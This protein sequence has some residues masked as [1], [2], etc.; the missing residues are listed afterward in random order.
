MRT[1]KVLCMRSFRFCLMSWC[2]KLSAKNC[3]SITRLTYF[4]QARSNILPPSIYLL[5]LSKNLFSKNL[6]RIS[7]G[8]RVWLLVQAAHLVLIGCSLSTFIASWLFISCDSLATPCLKY[9][10]IL[11]TAPWS[12]HRRLIR[13][14]LMDGGSSCLLKQPPDHVTSLSKKQVKKYISET[15]LC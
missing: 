3:N 1:K 11:F 15:E 7:L 6:L 2:T 4:W 13:W 8:L 5:H 9:K 10:L 14:R 12:L